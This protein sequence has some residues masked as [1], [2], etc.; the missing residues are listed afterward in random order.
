MVAATENGGGT[1]VPPE[2]R[3]YDISVLDRYE[4]IAAVK[5]VNPH[6]IDYL[7]LVNV[8]GQWL[9]ANVLYT[10]NRENR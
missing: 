3:V 5:A 4:E 8:S 2:E 6:W 9:I 7:Q 1:R 10:E